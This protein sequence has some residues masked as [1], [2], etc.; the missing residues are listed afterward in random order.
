LGFERRAIA[1]A[2]TWLV[3]LCGVIGA[4]VFVV[5]YAGVA[6]LPAALARLPFPGWP[7]GMI[8]LGTGGGLAL[9]AIIL[10]VLSAR[11]QKAAAT[12][13][14]SSGAR[15]GYDDYDDGGYGANPDGESVYMPAAGS[16]DDDEQGGWDGDAYDDAASAYGPAQSGGRYGAPGRSSYR[17]PN[18]PNRRGLLSGQ[19]GGDDDGYDDE[20]DGPP[21]RRGGAPGKSSPG[22]SRYRR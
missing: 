6:G 13:D 22:G 9:A 4:L 5:F 12:S 3:A 14:A 15:G 10:A 1:T 19:Y 8:F 11:K 16:W 17:A 2:E 20:D 7:V 18:P 21:Q